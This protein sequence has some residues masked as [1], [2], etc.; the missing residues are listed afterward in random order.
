[1]AAPR[2]S[3]LV[4]A[5]NEEAI[6]D[7]CLSRLAFAD[8]LVV[9][10]DKCTDRSAEITRKY[11]HQVIEGSWE[12][13]GYRRNLGIGACT[14]E[15]ILEV[16]ADEYVGP[17][18]AR[19]IR[20]A[21]DADAYDVHTIPTLNYIGKRPVKY[22]WGGGTFGKH[23]YQGL[24]RK[25]FKVW[26]MQ[27]MHPHVVTTGR[28]GP[29]LKNRIDHYMDRSIS[30]MLARL[31]RNTSWRA[32]DL[33]EKGETTNSL[34]TMFRKFTSRFWKCYIMRK[35]YKEGALGIVI[36]LCGALYPLI[37]HIKAVEEESQRP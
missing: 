30:D 12:R 29:D 1:M 20:A 32:R 26:G 9:V 2:L 23:E 16:D 27:R 35:A 11:A 28:I 37:A 5:H 14:G 36:A 31:D 15:W 21:V 10:L 4:V 34:A 24:Y 8:E 3:A 6:L 18:L 7:G 25:G 19:E 33:V 22:G 13:D 17:E